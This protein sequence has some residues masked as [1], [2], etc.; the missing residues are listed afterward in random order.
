MKHTTLSH[1]VANR[2]ADGNRRPRE[3]G[4]MHRTELDS[5]LRPFFVRTSVYGMEIHS[6]DV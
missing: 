4:T 1:R 6:V 3:E 2:A 5:D